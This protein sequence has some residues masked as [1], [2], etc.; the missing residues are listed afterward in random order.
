MRCH[1]IAPL[2]LA[3]LLSHL[4]CLCCFSQG[5]ISVSLLD[6]F[7]ASVG[8]VLNF[9]A[10]TLQLVDVGLVNDL[11]DVR[12]LLNFAEVLLKFVSQVI[13]LMVLHAPRIVELFN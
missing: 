3:S 4:G 6:C 8:L 9:C 11:R 1:G 2:V 12:L 10:D 7:D 5:L 13:L